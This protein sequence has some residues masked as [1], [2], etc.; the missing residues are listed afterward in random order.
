MLMMNN[1]NVLWEKLLFFFLTLIPSSM[2][3]IFLSPS[4]YFLL[5]F[6]SSSLFSL[7]FV[8]LPRTLCLVIAS[9]LFC[10][11]PCNLCSFLPLTI[12]LKTPTAPR[13]EAWTYPLE[14]FL[15]SLP[16]HFLS[17]LI[18]KKPFCLPPTHAPANSPPFRIKDTLFS[19]QSSQGPAIAQ[20]GSQM[21][22]NISAT[23]AQVPPPSDT[24]A[25]E[26][27]ADASNE[28]GSKDSKQH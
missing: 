3:L 22:K 21:A 23:S 26:T 2:Y 18:G 8:F 20:Q 19:L 25:R 14:R 5:P 24:K 9:P 17:L 28:K 10:F 13:Y 1:V 16:Y 12:I 27:A 6:S 15:I 7:L 4:F 11:H